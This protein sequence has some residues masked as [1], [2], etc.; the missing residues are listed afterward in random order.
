[1]RETAQTTKVWKVFYAFAKSSESNISLNDCLETGPL[2]QNLLWD[3]LIRTRFQPILLCED[4]QKAF[5]QIQMREAERNV[6][7]LHWVES[8]ES[9]KINIL[10]ISRLGF[11][12]PKS[13]FILEGKK[14]K[15]HFE[16]YRGEFEET[17]N[18]IEKQGYVC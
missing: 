15:S 17:V 11:G 6:F 5:L 8:M 4:I 16:N 3:A 10:R 7:R 18:R 12:L 14:M 1:M 13:P 2:L 9:N